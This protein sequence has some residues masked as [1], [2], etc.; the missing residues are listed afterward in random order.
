MKTIVAHPGQQHSYHVAA[1]VKSAGC[2][3]CYITAIY[4][5][6]KSPWMKMIKLFSNSSDKAKAIKRKCTHLEDK[7]VIQYYQLLSL[8]S[9]FLTRYLKGCNI[10]Y[11]LDRKISDQFG[12]KVAKYAI[13]KK[14]DAVICFST[15]ERMC[16]KYLEKHAPKIIRLVDC[17]NSPINYMKHIYNQ[18]IALSCKNGL[19]KEVPSFWNNKILKNQTESIS[20]T[21]LFL[22]PSQFVKQGLKY[23]GVSEER[24]RI[25]PYGSNFAVSLSP[26]K[27]ISRVHFIYVGQI[28]YRKG[29]HHLLKVFSELPQADI[30]LIGS[31][32]YNSKLYKKYI[33]FHNIF[34]V[35]HVSNDRI[36]DYLTKANVFVFPSLS[37]GFSLACLEALS[38]GLPI[39][40]TEN[41]GINDVIINGKNG[42]VI[43]ASDEDMLKKKVQHFLQHPEIIPDMSQCA[44]QTAKEFT[45]DNYRDKL[46]NYLLFCK[47]IQWGR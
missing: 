14:V 3:D 39:I 44:I 6:E 30:K 43:K 40:C 42:Y 41:S 33:K 17:A 36:I 45:W 38:Q 1:A 26:Q 12:I 28:T 31:I 35:G 13:K 19:K 18:D 37:E 16:F 4:D 5:K 47:R 7:E 46:G 22:A 25:I 27:P 8:F 24:I 29:V 34:F 10:G 21:N 11:W 15:N 2:L 9:I 32:P 20:L 23:N